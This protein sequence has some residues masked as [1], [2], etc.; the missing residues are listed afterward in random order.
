VSYALETIEP[1]VSLVKS[2]GKRSGVEV[3]VSGFICGAGS[4]VVERSP[5]SY[6]HNSGYE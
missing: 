6:G 2:V 4:S 3:G 5:C 1:T